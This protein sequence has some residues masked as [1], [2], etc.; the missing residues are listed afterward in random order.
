[1]KHLNPP[2]SR[3]MQSG[4]KPGIDTGTVTQDEPPYRPVDHTDTVGVARADDN[5]VGGHLL[6]KKRQ[7]GRIVREVRI[8]FDDIVRIVIKGDPEP[9]R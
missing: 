4:Y 8:H 1:M 3:K 6:D 7:H 5:I 2:C 9:S